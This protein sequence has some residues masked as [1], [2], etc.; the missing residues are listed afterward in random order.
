M[1]LVEISEDEYSSLT[2]G[3]KIL[4]TIIT[5]VN[6]KLENRL[7]DLSN[8][9]KIIKND[10]SAMD[11]KLE[12]SLSVMN[13]KLENSLSVMNEKFDR[14]LSE[15]RA[16]HYDMQNISLSGNGVSLSG[17]VSSSQAAGRSPRIKLNSFDTFQ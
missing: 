2:D 4:A 7:Y 8:E 15:T 11:E 14:A 12:N 1:S 16:R 6:K 13:E 3:E 5:K 17:Y 10:L 9:I